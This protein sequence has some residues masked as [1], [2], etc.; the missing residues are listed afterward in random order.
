MI[1]PA[2]DHEKFM[3]LL[4]KHEPV[5]RAYVRAG[6]QSAQDVAEVMQDV[7]IVAW[8][9]FD[10]LDEPEGFGKWMT[11]IARYEIMKFRQTKARDRLVLDDDIM[12]KI[13]AEGV[14]ETAGRE[15]WV[16]AMEGCLAQLPAEQRSLLLAAYEPGAS[17]KRLAEK[18]KR[19][20]NALYQTL[21][22]LRAQ[23]ANCIESKMAYE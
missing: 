11:V 19:T 23:L 7:S 1:E 21:H 10:Q 6:V 3:Q 16:D 14:E 20:P 18:T 8:R 12:D 4:A 15:A 17:I 13:M 22:R 9:K 2:T 5:V